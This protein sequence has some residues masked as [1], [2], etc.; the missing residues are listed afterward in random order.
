M[1]YTFTIFNLRLYEITMK[2]IV[3]ISLS[4]TT[5]ILTSNTHAADQHVKLTIAQGKNL[6]SAQSQS[7]NKICMLNKKLGS[8]PTCGNSKYIYHKLTQWKLQYRE[9][10]RKIDKKSS[11]EN[12]VN[13]LKE[14]QQISKK[15]QTGTLNISLTVNGSN[16]QQA[17][18]LTACHAQWSKQ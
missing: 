3:I 16:K 18:S 9:L 8:T 15:P 6:S 12:C 13:F 17:L 11:D 7:I 1:H 5:L 14:W 2:K 4:I 10:F